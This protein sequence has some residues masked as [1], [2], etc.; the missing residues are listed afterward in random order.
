MTERLRTETRDRPGEASQSTHRACCG[1]RA[2]QVRA[3]PRD[4]QAV[5]MGL[6]REAEPQ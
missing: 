1:V 5:E 3:L 2:S 6:W 4:G